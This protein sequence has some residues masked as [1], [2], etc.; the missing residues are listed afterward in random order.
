MFSGNRLQSIRFW[1]EGSSARLR[2]MLR[3]TTR[4][5]R[6]RESFWLVPTL[7]S[8]AAL[9]FALLTAW[10]DDELQLHGLGSEPLGYSGGADSAQ[11]FLITVAGSIITVAAT[12]FSITI[13]VL[14]LASAQFGPRLIRNF[15]RDVGNQ[16]VLG[17]FLATFVYCLVVL[18]VVRGGEDEF[19]PYLS[20]A[21]AS[22]LTLASLGVLIYFIAH[23]SHTIQVMNIVA[24]IGDDL[25]TTITRLYPE[26]IEGSQHEGFAQAAEADA[27]FAGPLRPVAA[28]RSGYV[29]AIDYSRLLEIAE[30]R[31][32][33]IQVPLRAG[34]FV[35]RGAAFAEVVIDDGSLPDDKALAQAIA[36]SFDISVSRGSDQD[37]E[38]HIDQL[39]EIACRALSPAINDPFTAMACIDRL[40]AGLRYLVRREMPTA[41]LRDRAGVLRVVVK[42]ETFPGSLDA[43]FNLIRQYGHQSVPVA[44]RLIENLAIIAEYTADPYELE[45]IKR[46][47]DMVRHSAASLMSEPAD[48]E[49][50]EERYQLVVRSLET[51]DFEAI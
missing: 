41:F 40:G 48:L 38:Y 13:A 32:M 27:L 4:V 30:S 50:L 14:A 17:T 39:V 45:A 16:I 18:R 2:P 42:T 22:V 21:V 44:L 49:A 11:A 28:R 34:Q 3:T 26:E 25:L 29:R 20:I 37:I 33:R 1:P 35:S 6:L 8:T 7:F 12:S 15:I 5:F 46:H 19:V 43:A 36:A 47:A 24:R 23:I 51:P 10:L 9:L 31:G